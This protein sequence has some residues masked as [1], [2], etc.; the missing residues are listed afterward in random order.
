MRIDP[1]ETSGLSQVGIHFPEDTMLGPGCEEASA[2][3]HNRVSASG[4]LLPGEARSV[5]LRSLWVG[6]FLFPK[7]HSVLQPVNQAPESLRGLNPSSR[8][9]D[10]WGH[11]GKPPDLVFHRL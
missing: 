6:C 5:S 2:Q 11:S 7:A 9:S 1:P 3:T 10:T 8:G 4:S